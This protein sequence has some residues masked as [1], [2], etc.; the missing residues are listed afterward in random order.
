MP[1][2]VVDP[3]SRQPYDWSHGLSP[4]QQAE[5]LVDCYRM[6]L[7]DDYAWGGM[8]ASR[9]VVV[10]HVVIHPGHSTP[11]IAGVWGASCDVTT[12]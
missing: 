11:P 1:Q 10:H 8:F 3:K 6:R 5:W 2:R 4:D 9:L 12:G 7:D